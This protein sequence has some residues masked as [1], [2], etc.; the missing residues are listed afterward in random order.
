[1]PRNLKT[2]DRHLMI[3]KF[4]NR[5]NGNKDLIQMLKCF[6]GLI[7]HLYINHPCRA[8]HHHI[9]DLHCHQ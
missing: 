8:A 3:K 2:L 1:M 6:A 9:T 7:V 4:Q 5:E